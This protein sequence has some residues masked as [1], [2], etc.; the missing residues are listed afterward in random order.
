MSFL[1]S[2]YRLQRETVANQIKL[3]EGSENM[4]YSGFLIK[5]GDYTIPA[6]KYLRA[7][8]YS[9]YRNIQDLDSYRDANG[10]L[11]R[12][13]LD[14][15]PNKVEFET[16]AM[17]TNTEF[18]DL[19][20]SIRA[21]YIVSKERKALVTLYI[22]ELDA[23]ETQEMYMPDPQP[24]IYSTAGGIIRYNAVRLAFIGY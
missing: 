3:L 24:S 1:Y 2:K 18:A 22:P 8:S 16:P 13:A 23:Y 17:L 7:D 4:A 19:M 10:V 14:H 21:N 6:D 15:V 12:E 5:V 11:H 9:V 20:G